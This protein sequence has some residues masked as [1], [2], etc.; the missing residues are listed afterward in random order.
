[1]ISRATVRG[2]MILCSRLTWIHDGMKRIESCQSC[3]E[4]EG[5]REVVILAHEK[6]KERVQG[7]GGG[8]I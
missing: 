3:L 1:M 7:L 5:L 4:L 6:R 8:Y 2:H